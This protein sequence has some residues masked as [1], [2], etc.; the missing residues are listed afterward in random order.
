VLAE[1]HEV[2]ATDIL[3]EA[4]AAYRA[5]RLDN[6]EA[7]CNRILE[8]QPDH[9]AS[10]QLL[11]ATLGQRGKQGRG[12]ELLKKAISLSPNSVDNQV[13]LAKLLRLDN[14]DA[15]AI[16]A[17]NKAIEIDPRSA[18]A[19]NDLGLIYLAKVDLAKA[20]DCFDQ[21][22]EINPDLTIANF[23]RGL[24]LELRG[25][26]ATAVAA[27]RR[28][29]ATDPG[30]AQAH[31]KLGNLLL[32]QGDRME[33]IECLR[34]AIAAKPD[35]SLAFI[36]QAKIL[37]EENK[38]V[39][40]EQQARR[41]LEL[42]PR[43][44]DAHCLLG[45]ILMELGHFHE[46]AASFDLALALNRGQ[47]AAY[48]NLVAVKKLAEA[49]R[50]LIAQIEWTLNNH[51][52]PDAARADLHFALGKGYDDLSEYDNA[53]QH[54]DQA[55]RLKHR[56]TSFNGQR[57]ELIVDRVTAK[58]TADFFSRNAA[59]GSNWE[60]PILIIGMPRS[61]TTLVEQILS[62]HPEIAAGGELTFWGERAVSFRADTN[63]AIDPA[64]V[65]HA[66]DDYRE[67]LTTISPT[68]RRVTDKRPH[69]FHFLG[70]IHAVFPRARIIHCQRHPVD[71]CLSIYFQN[72][73]RRMDFA[74]DRADLLVAY[75][76]YLRLM[77]HW[78]SIMPANCLFELQYEELVADREAITRRMIE[79]CDLDWNDSCLHSERNQRAV[80]TAS[81]W[82]ARQPVYRTSV[83]RWRRYEPWIGALRE[84]LPHVERTSMDNPTK[85]S[86]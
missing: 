9:I 61:G 42:D 7:L 85:S 68:A 51:K 18:G 55:N 41:A 53:I 13:Q 71:T 58:F 60:V 30:F 24:A 26:H 23:N 73:G 28:A 11:A 80:H 74:Y 57:Q 69:N 31:A 38:A 59:L 50:P 78:R 29:L 32:I 79:F 70:L 66:A 15:E 62:S 19:Y 63:G 25:D 46:A 33:G 75:R 44:S 64:W 36:M 6:V 4:V 82:Q 35:S 83:A 20:I 49:D 22:V 48:C 5:G 45:S 56:Y 16:A 67:L 39:V 72:F 2:Q 81:V 12:I 1:T 65:R 47:I 84:L 27:F 17:L 34:R 40:A 76:Q 43:S 3:R 37:M 52:L 21:A 77:D 10:L 8:H 86:H 14:R 54:F